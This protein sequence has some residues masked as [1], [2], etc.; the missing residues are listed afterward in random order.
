MENA[1]TT[2]NMAATV[3]REHVVLRGNGHP[4]CVLVVDDD[5][6]MRL[7][8]S[9]NL[10]LEGLTVLEAADGRAGLARARAERPDLVLTDV[11]M[12][13]LDGFELAEELRRDKRT[14]A[15]PLIF[16]SGETRAAN[17]TRARALGALAYLRKPFDPAAL[18]SLVAGV[19][20]SRCAGPPAERLPG[21]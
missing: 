16:L 1:S 21:D 6:A 19:V 8:C 3:P 20:A 14:R 2:P 15:I 5:P 11:T 13:G 17:D 4:P 7:L 9:I 12:P 10:Q 18:A